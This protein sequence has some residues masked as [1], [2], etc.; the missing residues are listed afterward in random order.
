MDIKI[1]IKDEKGN[2]IHAD[3]VAVFTC[4]KNNKEYVA[5]NNG[6]LV[7]SQDSSYNNLDILEIIKEENNTF[8]VSNIPDNEWDAVKD[9]L[10]NEIFA[11]IKE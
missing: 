2:T 10:I 9:T 6:D 5:L 11:K 7:F 4:A 8:F 3:V 1:L